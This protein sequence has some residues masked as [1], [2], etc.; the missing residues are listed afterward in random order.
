MKRAL[1]LLTALIATAGVHAQMTSGDW[2]VTNRSQLAPGVFRLTPSTGVWENLTAGDVVSYSGVSMAADNST[3]LLMNVRDYTLDT[4]DVATGL[5]AGPRMTTIPQQVVLDQDGSYLTAQDYGLFRINPATGVE[6][7]VWFGFNQ[8]I[9]GVCIDGQTGDYVTVGMGPFFNGT[10]TRVD[11]ISLLSTDI[12]TGLGDVS[13]IDYNPIAGE[14]LVANGDQNYPVLR[15]SAAG[16]VSVFSN[17]APSGAKALR[18]D[19]TTG[20]VLVAGVNSVALLNPAGNVLASF[21]TPTS[22]GEAL[23]VDFYGSRWT[24]TS[25][26]AAGGFDFAI[27][28]RDPTA[29]N[30][31]YIAALSDSIS[32]G[33]PFNDGTGYCVCLQMND[34]FWATF[35]GLPGLVDGFSGALDASGSAT[36]Y[37]RLPVGFPEGIRLHAQP[38]IADPTKPYGVRPGN[39]VSFTTR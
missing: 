8:F 31:L 6:T 37:V 29:S 32:A 4:F 25:G 12:A 35:G 28:F 17:F 1:T 34:L 22:F 30:R 26:Q 36:G 21:V 2:I 3:M 27:Q 20:N 14:F 38:L 5:S 19:P 9:R 18:I 15:V 16:V 11:P 33:F 39:P 7:L 13:C 23:G 24:S 10:M